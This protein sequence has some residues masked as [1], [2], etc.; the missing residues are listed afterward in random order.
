MTAD[1]RELALAAVA[2]WIEVHTEQG[3]GTERLGISYE[4]APLTLSDLRALVDGVDEPCDQ[5]EHARSA[6]ADEVQACGIDDCWCEEWW[7]K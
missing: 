6:H 1:P 7:P 2:R 3:A 5:C 4:N